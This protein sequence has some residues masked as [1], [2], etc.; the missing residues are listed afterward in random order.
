MASVPRSLFKLTNLLKILH[1][2]LGCWI[3]E[4]NWSLPSDLPRVAIK[5]D[6]DSG[7]GYKI[8]KN[9]F[10]YV[11]TATSAGYFLIVDVITSASK[12]L[13]QKD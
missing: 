1:P 9:C 6:D 4:A 11:V 8:G 5:F 13:S 3:S 12:N 7:R 2:H 10:R